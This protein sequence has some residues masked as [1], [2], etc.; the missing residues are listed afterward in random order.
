MKRG[1][2]DRVCLAV[3]AVTIGFAGG[4]GRTPQLAANADCIAATDALWTAINAK[5]PPLVDRSASEIVRL[6]DSGQL[7]DEAFALL[8]T[9]VASARAGEWPQAR[10]SLKAFIVGQRPAQK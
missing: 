10:K 9:V 3:L 4:C 8:S 7:N 6:H 2:R 5:R 1:W